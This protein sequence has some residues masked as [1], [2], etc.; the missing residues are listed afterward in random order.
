MRVGFRHVAKHGKGNDFEAS[1]FPPNILLLPQSSASHSLLREKPNSSAEAL[2]T[3]T[4][5]VSWISRNPA[6]MGK[7]YVNGPRAPKLGKLATAK[8]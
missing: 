5:T 4:H 8:A 1:L 3:H 6:A 2:E 7:Q